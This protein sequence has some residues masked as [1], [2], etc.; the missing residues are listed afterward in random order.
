MHWKAHCSEQTRS[1]KSPCSMIASMG[2]QVF[3]TS[4]SRNADLRLEPVA[5]SRLPSP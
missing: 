5:D 2:F 4:P 3:G 1:A